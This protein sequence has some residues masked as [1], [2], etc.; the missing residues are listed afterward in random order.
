MR[1]FKTEGIVIKRRNTGEA[2]RL[3]T[4]FTKAHGKL[5][6]KAV[7]VRRITSRRSAHTELLNYGLFSLYKGRSYPILTEVDTKDHFAEV[8]TDLEKISAAYH[9]CELV[10]GLCP[11]H[12]ENR[13]VF[14]L[15]K[16]TL[17]QLTVECNLKNEI[18]LFEVELLYMLGF[19]PRLTPHYVQTFDAV[20]F[21]ENLLARKLRTKRFIEL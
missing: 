16:A 19:L 17:E 4:V 6:I 13:G 5:L 2:D 11:D 10:D 14:Y 18:K 15:L 3:L 20:P 8:K 1:A 7:G 21:V 12:Q 9:L